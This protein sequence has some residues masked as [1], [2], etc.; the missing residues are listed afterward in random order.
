[1]HYHLIY[2]AWSLLATTLKVVTLKIH[3][4]KPLLMDPS[5]FGHFSPG[6]FPEHWE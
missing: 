6:S 3:V 5:T 4:S 2:L 1:M